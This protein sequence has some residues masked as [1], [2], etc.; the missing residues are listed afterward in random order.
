MSRR[1][2]SINEISNAITRE[3]ESYNEEITL[4][5]K[6]VIGDVTN[7]FVERT[8]NDARVGKR[9]GKYKKAISS[10]TLFEN[11][12]KLVKVWYV[13]SPE[14]RL[15]HLLNNGHAKKGGGFVRGDNHISKNEELAEKELEQGIK[16]VIENGY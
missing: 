15:A 13:R 8:K 2:S 4:A 7:K 12:H 11:K 16:A 1:A 10:K 6:K 3:L 14:Y 9:K 5:T